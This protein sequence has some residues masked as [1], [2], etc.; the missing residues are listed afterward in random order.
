MAL[1]QTITF[2]ILGTLVGSFLNVCVDRIPLG[3]S[4][5]SPA[6]HCPVCKRTLRPLELIPVFSYLILRG[7]CR[8]CGA[9]IP[10]RVWVVEVFTGLLFAGIALR[11]GFQIRT[12]FLAIQISLLVIM[13][14]IDLEHQRVPNLVSYPAIAI[15]LLAIPFLPSHRP[16]DWLLGGALGFGLL[17]LIALLAPGGMGMGDVKLTAFIGLVVGYPEIILALFLSFVLG[18]LIAGV[19]LAMGRIKRRDPIAFGPFLALGAILT[20]FYSEPLIQWWLSRI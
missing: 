11:F 1:L 5:V 6:S 2:G 9:K 19:L 14:G 10:L 13:A 20:I 7:R 18:G 16:L 17:L 4:I 15:S 12:L 8:T 3:G